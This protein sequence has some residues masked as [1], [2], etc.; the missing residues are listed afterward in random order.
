MIDCGL[1]RK[2][3]VVE[4]VGRAGP[5]R[6]CKGEV[7]TLGPVHLQDFFY[8]LIYNSSRRSPSNIRA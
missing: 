4:K 5:T 1:S 3:F 7:G 8:Y 2:S 6:E